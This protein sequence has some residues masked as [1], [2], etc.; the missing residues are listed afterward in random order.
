[1]STRF[2]PYSIRI[3]NDAGRTFAIIPITRTPYAYEEPHEV[4]AFDCA[5]AAR[6]LLSLEAEGF[7]AII[8]RVQP[9]PE[10]E[11]FYSDDHTRLRSIV[12][13]TRDHNR[14]PWSVPF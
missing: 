10:W 8:D 13:W 5:A 11:R 14:I 7:K 6:E 1:M 3:L 12:Y 9:A 4:H 2:T